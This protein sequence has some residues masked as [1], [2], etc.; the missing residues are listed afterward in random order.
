M[1]FEPGMRVRKQECVKR[2]NE[3]TNEQTHD[4]AKTSP[5]PALRAR[6]ATKRY[7]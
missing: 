3:Q 5:T 7:V 6:R 2:M 1:W 4:L